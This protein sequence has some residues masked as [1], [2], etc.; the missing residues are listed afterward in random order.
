MQEDVTH[1][2]TMLIVQ[3]RVDLVEKVDSYRAGYTQD[4]RIALEK[5]CSKLGA[6]LSYLFRCRWP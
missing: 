2:T 3:R 6:G 5:V 4:E 1:N